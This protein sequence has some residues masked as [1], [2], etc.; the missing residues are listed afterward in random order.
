MAKRLT[1]RPTDRSDAGFTL[2]EMSI[3]LIIIGL[4]VGMVAPLIGQITDSTREKS[5]SVK[6]DN[7]E[8][9]IVAFVR[10]EGRI[11]CPADPTATPLGEE[12]ATCQSTTTDDGLVPYRSLGLSEE[13]VI[14]GCG[15]YI[16]YHVDDAYANNATLNSPLVAGGFC[17]VT[18]NNI[19]VNDDNGDDLSPSQDVVYV[20]VSHGENGFGRFNPPASA[21]I[22][23]TGGGTFEDENADSDD[24]FVAT[25]FFDANATNGPYDD[26]VAWSTKNN[27]ANAVQEFG[28][29]S[30]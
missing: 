22:N 18:A 24:T 8:E 17:G 3:V 10:S 21:R 2:L 20:L 28:C 4:I 14:D 29:S 26:Q 16:S 12:R 27:I 25:R 1:Y 5:T 13:A 6:L 23:A 11:P 19:T 30:D 9:A 15:Q 7:I